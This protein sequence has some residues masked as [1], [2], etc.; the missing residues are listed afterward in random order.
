MRRL[1]RI[2]PVRRPATRRL[3]RLRATVRDA[4]GPG[5]DARRTAEWH[6]NRG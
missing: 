5:R 6:L 3:I 2:G 4:L 1:L